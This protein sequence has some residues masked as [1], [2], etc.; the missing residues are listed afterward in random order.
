[1]L[2][3]ITKLVSGTGNIMTMVAGVLM[4][5]AFVA[6]LLTV[7]NYIWQRN[8]GGA[9]GLKQAGNMLWWSVF[10]LFIMVAVWGIV[11]FLSSNL[12]I[13]IGGCTPKPSP[14]PGQPVQ[15]NCKPGGS[16]VTSGNGAAGGQGTCSS[17]S[18]RPGGCICTSPS[19]C[20]SGSCSAGT[21]AS[22]SG[23][24]SA[25][26]IYTTSGSGSGSSGVASCQSGSAVRAA[27]GDLLYCNGGTMGDPCQSGSCSVGRC[28]IID[29]TF[30]QYGTCVN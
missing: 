15:D 24:G 3:S 27:N 7:V 17:A 9:D 20:F 16:G 4:T 30:S 29:P 28:N 22:G 21:C 25:G 26:T 12:G 13:G 11:Y 6:F 23:A 14:I 1:M 5:I 8:K 2:D 19:Q 10:A 18:G